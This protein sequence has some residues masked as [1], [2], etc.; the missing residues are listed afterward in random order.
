MQAVSEKRLKAFGVLSLLLQHAKRANS[1]PR[2]HV[3]EGTALT[4]VG[5]L[6]SSMADGR[7]I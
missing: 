4:S 1:P 2:L 3:V 6:H 5:F 7:Q